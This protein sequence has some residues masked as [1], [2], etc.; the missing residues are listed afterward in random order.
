MLDV[1]MIITLVDMGKSHV[2]KIYIWCW[3]D[4]AS[5]AL[6]NKFTIVKSWFSTVI[7]MVAYLCPLHAR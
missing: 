3:Y 5:T 1:N 6:V 7:G 4:Y 2:H